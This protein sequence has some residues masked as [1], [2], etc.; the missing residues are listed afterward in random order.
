LDLFR[1]ILDKQVLDTHKTKCGKVDGLIMRL[2]SDG[3]RLQITHIEMGSTT[4]ARRL[5]PRAERWIRAWHKHFGS[6]HSIT[7]YRIE[8]RKVTDVG[9]DIEVAIE[10]GETPYG[11]SRNWLRRHVLKYL[12]G[13]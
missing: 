4:L 10:A 11:R 3:T 12:P 9:V 8:W 5:G 6:P 2:G 1:D 7:P 13:K